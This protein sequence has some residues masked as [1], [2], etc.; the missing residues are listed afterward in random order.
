MDPTRL[1]YHAMPRLCESYSS[2]AELSAWEVHR[3]A[4]LYCDLQRRLSASG[5]I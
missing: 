2:I 5:R 1:S 4:R 3:S